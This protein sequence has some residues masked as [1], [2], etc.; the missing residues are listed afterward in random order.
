MTDRKFTREREAALD[1][2]QAA[3]REKITEAAAWSHVF[4]RQNPQLLLPDYVKVQEVFRWPTALSVAAGDLKEEKSLK[5]VFSRVSARYQAPKRQQVLGVADDLIRSEAA[6]TNGRL[7][8]FEDVLKVLDVAER[9]FDASY[10][11]LTREQ[12]K[13]WQKKHPLQPDVLEYAFRENQRHFM[14][15]AI[16]E[17]REA[18]IA[19]RDGK[20]PAPRAKGAKPPQP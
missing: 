16:S 20:T 10:K 12:V 6:K 18:V 19:L 3:M 1:E 8:A 11:P 9:D 14:K 15:E 4:M 17:L 2:I 5:E 7:S 13:Y